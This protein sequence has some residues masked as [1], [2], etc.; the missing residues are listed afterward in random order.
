MSWQANPAELN[1]TV[2]VLQALRDPT[3]SDHREAVSG[4][5]AFAQNPSFALHVIHVFVRGAAYVDLGLSM[6][7][8]MLGGMVL[9]N[10]V[11]PALPHLPPQ[12]H[13]VLRL[14]MLEALKDPLPAVQNIAGIMFG[15]FT[16]LFTIEMWGD[17]LP[18]LFSLLDVAEHGQVGWTDGALKAVKRICED[19]SEKLLFASSESLP[20]PSSPSSPS[21]SS[22]SASAAQTPLGMLVPR[23]VSLLAAPWTNVRLQALESMNPLLYMLSI[24]APRE[25]QAEGSSRQTVGRG[26]EA[27]VI[28]I[29]A[30][31]Q[32]N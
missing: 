7:L 8:R 16:E 19:S 32:V 29:N 24:P 6:E 2:L 9:K 12:V 26:R 5:S 3:R 28:H 30:F 15:R 22:V 20:L 13:Q 4:L 11:F 31:L 18:P 21:S 23:L 14:E 1:Q 17:L 10:Y 25:G 27:L